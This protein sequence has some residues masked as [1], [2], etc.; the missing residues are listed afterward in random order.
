MIGKPIKQCSRLIRLMRINFVLVRYNLDEVILATRWFYPLRFL[1]YFNPWYWFLKNKLTR[2]QR[3]RL[4][5][6][7]LGPIF[8]KAG[9]VLST[10]RDLIPDDITEELAKLQDR[11][12]PF[13]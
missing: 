4:A 10:R 7:D 5:L 6:E 3:I 11:V 12:P 2:G 8:I 9:Q 13:C 1:S